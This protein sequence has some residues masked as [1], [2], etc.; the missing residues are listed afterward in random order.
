VLSRYDEILQIEHALA[1]EKLRDELSSFHNTVLEK[2]KVD[3]TTQ[4][5]SLYNELTAAAEASVE[6]TLAEQRVHSNQRSRK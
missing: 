3:A 1:L 4:F 5:E 2:S 6:D